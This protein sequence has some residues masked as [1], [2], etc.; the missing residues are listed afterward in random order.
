MGNINNRKSYIQPVLHDVIALVPPGD[1]RHLALARS[2]RPG[3]DLVS[4]AHL[5]L[6]QLAELAGL[7]LTDGLHQHHLAQVG[8]QEGRPVTLHPAARALLSM[9]L[10]YFHQVKYFYTEIFPSTARQYKVGSGG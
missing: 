1:G 8:R 4:E 10:K 2:E 3:G 5:P 9:E 7:P 6:H